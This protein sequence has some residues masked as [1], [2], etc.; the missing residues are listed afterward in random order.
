MIAA[1]KQEL[2]ELEIIRTKC[3]TDFSFFVRYFFK[4]LKGIKFT[5]SKHHYLIADTLSKVY[6][7]EI[8]HLIINVPPRYS[9]TELAVKMFSA[10]CYAKN[11]E[12]EFIHLSYSDALAMDNS[13]AIRTIIKSKEFHELWPHITIK[14]TKDSKKS[15]GTEQG[16]VFYA[17]ASGGSITGFG[18]GKIND[19]EHHSG[20]GFGGCVIIDD[21]LKP[22]DAHSS[23]RREAVNR[24]WDET[25]KSRFNSTKTP[26]IVIMQRLH[27]NDLCAELLNDSEYKFKHIVQPAILYEGTDHEQA[28]WPEKHSLEQLKLMQK[29]NRYAFSGQM[30]Q[31]PSPVGGGLIKGEWFQRYKVIP[32]LAYRAVFVDTAQK[33]K[34]HNDYQVAQLWGICKKGNIYL[35]DMIREKFQAYELEVKI[36]DFWN[37]HKQ[38]KNGNLRFMAIEDKSSG[39]ELIQKLQKKTTPKIPVK[40]IPRGPGNNKLSRLMDVQGYIESGYVYL[41]HNSLDKT[42]VSDFIEECESFT[43]NDTHA[44]DDQVDAMCDAISFMIHNKRGATSEWL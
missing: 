39:T 36:P 30:Q 4:K 6:N 18:A 22:D 9:K 21:P 17:T 15:W 32:N 3:K 1:D 33:A 13:D 12:C 43:A 25:I 19:F 5:F 37:K 20:H 31:S 34:Q 40:P 7:G 16:G 26:C 35:I 2:A 8:T 29:K 28:L 27:E 42:W 44:H 11:P 10:W 23:P 24:R 38:D 14:I 41:P